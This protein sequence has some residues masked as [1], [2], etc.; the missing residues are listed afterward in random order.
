MNLWDEKAKTYARFKGK[1]LPLQKEIFAYLK[2]LGIDFKDKTIID[3]G[4]GT[5]VWTLHLAKK[6]SEIYALDGSKAMLEI[7]ENDSKTLGLKN[8]QFCHANFAD[9]AFTKSFDIA[10]LTMSAALQTKQD[11]E[12]FLNLGKERIHLSWADER[13]SDF[14]TPIFEA[15]KLSS[16]KNK[17]ANLQDFLEENGVE[18]QMKIFSETRFAKRS[19]E[20]ALQNALW[21]LKAKGI[22]ADE[23][24][25]S[26]FIDKKGINE[27]IDSKMKLLVF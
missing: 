8:L 11:Y 22:F 21:H 26:K 17:E 16:S 9:F 3:I 4:C 1:L 6:A 27:R 7:L 20:E 25:I 18:F 10:F 13:K 5:G 23:S 2:E 12:K 24:Q 14:L 15:F 19:Y